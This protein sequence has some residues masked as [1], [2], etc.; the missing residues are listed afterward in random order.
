VDRTGERL[1]ADGSVAGIFDRCVAIE[2]PGNFVG[3]VPKLIVYAYVF[4]IVC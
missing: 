4:G 3:A 1:A 2:I